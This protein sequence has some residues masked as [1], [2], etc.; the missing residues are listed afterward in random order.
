MGP[1]LVCAWGFGA[2]EEHTVAQWGSGSLRV[3]ATPF[4]IALMGRGCVRAV[5]GRPDVRH[6]ALTVLDRRVE[7]RAE[8]VTVAGRRLTFR[9]GAH[10]AAGLPG[11]GTRALHH[12]VGK[13][14]VKG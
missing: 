8:L 6:L 13:L 3:L 14:A 9:V 5:G 1:G 2:S 7:A 10:D 12:R 11:E 4:M